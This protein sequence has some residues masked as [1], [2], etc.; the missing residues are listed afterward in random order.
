MRLLKNVLSQLVSLLL[1]ITVCVIVPRLIE[2]EFRGSGGWSLGIGLM[3]LAIGLVVLTQ[4]IATFIRVGEGTLAPW[5]PPRKL[6]TS[7]IYA[8]VRNPMILG[9]ILILIGE[10]LALSSWRIL[11][12]AAIVFV[13]NEVYFPISEEPGLER[14]FGEE[15]REYRSNVPRWLPRLQPYR[16]DTHDT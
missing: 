6:I 3:S 4:T 7:G 5:S 10:G 8:Y 13:L 1:P 2:P 9:V 14:R 15:Y 16:G 11:T 12:W